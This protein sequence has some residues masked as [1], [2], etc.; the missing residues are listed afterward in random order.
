MENED[1]RTQSREVLHERR[2]QVI[3]LHRKGVGVMQIV[4]QTGLSWSGVNTALRLFEQGGA[5]AL[6]PHARGKK[7]GSGRSLIA[8]QELAIRMTIIDKRPEQI[9]ME[10]ALWSRAAVRELIERDLGL[11]LSVRA[12]GPLSAAGRCRQCPWSAQP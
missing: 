3:R 9:K 6:K 4:E 1:A 5:A 12:V 11:K 10:F 2:K 7:P 8:E